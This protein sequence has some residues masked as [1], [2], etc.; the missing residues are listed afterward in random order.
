MIDLI[1]A[2]LVRWVKAADAFNFIA[3]E[4]K[5]KADFAAGGKQVDNATAYR[6]F[7]SVGDRVHAEIAVGL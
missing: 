7:A 1:N 4:I 6:E 5:A 3:E 2:A